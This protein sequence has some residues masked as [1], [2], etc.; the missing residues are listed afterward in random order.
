KR[1]PAAQGRRRHC[2]IL[3]PKMKILAVIAFTA[4]LVAAQ[5]GATLYRQNCAMCHDGG[6]DRAPSRDSFKAMSADRVL[7]AMETGPMISMAS[8]RTAAERRQIAEF[9]TGKALTGVLETKP[10]A[11]AM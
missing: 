9:L 1:I 11:E 5:D 10:R 2:D 7:A 8:R 3:L 6:M 4:T